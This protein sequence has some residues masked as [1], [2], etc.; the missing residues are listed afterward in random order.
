LLWLLTFSATVGCT[1]ILSATAHASQPGAECPDPTILTEPQ[2]AVTLVCTGK[3]FPTRSATSLHGLSEARP[4]SAFATDG[5]PEWADGGFW[6]PDLE[7]VGDHY[8]LYYSARLQGTRRHCIG[9]A[10]S[11]R[12]DGGFRDLGVPLIDDGP[13]RAIDPALLSVG[14]QLYLFYKRHP[15]AAGAPS[16]IVG[17]LLSADGLDVVGSRVT[18]LRSRLGGW[19]HRVVEAPAPIQLGDTTYLLYSGGSFYR[20]GYAEGEAARTGDP[21]GPYARVSA[22]PVLQGDGRWAGTGGGS[23]F[24]D[25]S[26]LLLAY[27]AFRPGERSLRRLLFIRE[28]VLT[29][30]ALRPVGRTREIR[31]RR[32]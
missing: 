10:V 24:R 1:L 13:D 23:I 12:P 28:L 8:L 11:D 2:P 19:E 16:V 17:R 26:Q 18:L 9:V 30:G 22:A 4:Q 6:A 25:G 32:R 3:G 31:L 14:G 29:G 27:A 15:H 5:R 21:L 7:H 20:R